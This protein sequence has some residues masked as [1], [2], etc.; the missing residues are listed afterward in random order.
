MEEG[1]E[2]EEVWIGK[3]KAK[4]LFELSDTFVQ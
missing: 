4:Q 1:S 2:S 3:D